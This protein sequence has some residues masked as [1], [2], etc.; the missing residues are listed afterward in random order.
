M[1][2]HPGIWGKCHLKIMFLPHTGYELFNKCMVGD[3]V[4]NTFPANLCFSLD[5]FFLIFKLEAASQCN[6]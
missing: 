5:V 1:S 4:Y 3:I 6:W 2:E